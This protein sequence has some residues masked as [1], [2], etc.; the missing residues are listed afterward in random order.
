MKPSRRWGTRWW[1]VWPD[2]GHSSDQTIWG[3]MSKFV[4][5]R[6]SDNEFN[7]PADRASLRLFDVPVNV[8]LNQQLPM[9]QLASDGCHLFHVTFMGR[10]A[11]LDR[12]ARVAGSFSV[13]L[14]LRQVDFLAGSITSIARSRT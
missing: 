12:Q 13:S 14:T 5:E 2:V 10:V 11:L 8:F 9:T 3:Q 7:L 6:F 1:A 4:T